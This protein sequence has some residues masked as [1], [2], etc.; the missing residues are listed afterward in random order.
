MMNDICY[1]H[2]LLMFIT[3]TDTGH[4]LGLITCL[5]TCLNGRLNEKMID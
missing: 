2:V 4:L 1:L 3:D 5:L